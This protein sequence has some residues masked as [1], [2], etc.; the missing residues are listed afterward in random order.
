MRLTIPYC[1]FH[2]ALAHAKQ[3]GVIDEFRR[4]ELSC[5]A[6]EC[7]ILSSEKIRVMEGM[8]EANARA[9]CQLRRQFG[10]FGHTVVQAFHDVSSDINMLRRATEE[11]FRILNDNV[12]H[13]HGDVTIISDSLNHLKAGLVFKKR[14]EAVGN[15]LSGILN[16]LSFGIAGS[17]IQAT[18]ALSVARIVDFGSIVHIRNA[19]SFTAST[20]TDSLTVDDRRTLLDM[21]TAINDMGTEALSDKKLDD[22]LDKRSSVFLIA[23][24]AVAAFPEEIGYADFNTDSNAQQADT[25]KTRDGLDP[26]MQDVVFES[27]PPSG[28]RSLRNDDPIESAEWGEVLEALETKVEDELGNDTASTMPA[29]VAY[30][31][32]AN[33]GSQR[34]EHFLFI[35]KRTLKYRLHALGANPDTA[36]ADAAQFFINQVRLLTVNST[37]T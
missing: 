13:L 34:R 29:K 33:R 27:P 8:I 21:A 28:E 37:T 6:I 25:P 12:D 15:L 35:V 31:F 2:T 23:A 7:Q 10:R 9:I 16:A 5:G 11:S 22:A 17:A 18:L 20:E 19:V 3:H 26:P 4:S 30:L 14:V 24:A 1:D 32:F 36:N